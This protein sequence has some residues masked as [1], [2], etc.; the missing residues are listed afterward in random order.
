MNLIVLLYQCWS[1]HRLRRHW[2]LLNATRPGPAWLECDYYNIKHQVRKLGI[3]DGDQILQP[4]RQGLSGS[5]P[6]R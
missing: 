4:Q 3:T 6:L 1:L 2:L 5:D